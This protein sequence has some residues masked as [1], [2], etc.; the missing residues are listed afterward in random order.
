M[1]PGC[2]PGL[3]LLFAVAVWCGVLYLVS[4]LK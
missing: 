3:L 1:R 4:L 2:R